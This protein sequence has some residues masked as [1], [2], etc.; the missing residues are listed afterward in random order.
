VKVLALIPL[1]VLLAAC[2]STMA[3]TK[4][5]H[6]L[7]PAPNAG[8]PGPPPAWIETKAGSSW[9]GFSSSCWRIGDAGVCADAAAPRCG[10]QGT[11]DM[12]VS[13][14]ETVRAH[15]GYDASEASVDNAKAQL[16]GRTVS[17]RVAESGPFALFT[18]GKQGDASYVACARFG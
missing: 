10:R 13:Q 5:S 7:G 14:G 8:K 3:S 1:A 18:K 12:D 11:P 17:W 6:P 9:L 16:D 2:G 15:L 4:P